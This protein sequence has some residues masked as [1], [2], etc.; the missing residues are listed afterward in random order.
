[1]SESV[2][3]SVSGV[4]VFCDFAVLAVYGPGVGV[5]VFVCTRVFVYCCY[6]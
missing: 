4:Y 2:S 3:V 5:C 1:M 6:D